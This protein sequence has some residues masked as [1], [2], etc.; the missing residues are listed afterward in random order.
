[1]KSVN[2]DADD[3]NVYSNGCSEIKNLNSNLFKIK[4]DYLSHLNLDT[5]KINFK[6]TFGDVKVCFD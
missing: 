3:D 5:I 1:M 2:F 6:E 4:S